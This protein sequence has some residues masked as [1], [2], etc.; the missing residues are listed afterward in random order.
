MC[1]R[2]SVKRLD[3]GVLLV[4]GI[5]LGSYLAA[6]ASGEFR[7]RVPSAQVIQ[8]SIAGGV[9]MGIGAAWAGGC[10]IGNALVQTSLLSWQGWIAL[11]F[12]V[13]GVGAA[14]WLLLIRP[15][16]RRRAE[17]AASR[18]PATV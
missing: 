4:L 3:W 1:I 16:Q 6:K 2:D 11:V 7:V 12:Q 8:R 10:S 9:L 13:L 5:L 18:V 17:R 14:A 15:R